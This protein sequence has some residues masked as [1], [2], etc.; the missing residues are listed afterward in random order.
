[1]IG[2]VIRANADRK[3][4]L[5]MTE[6]ER[7]LLV[8]RREAKEPSPY[9]EPDPEDDGPSYEE[10]YEMDDFDLLGNKHYPGRPDCPWCARLAETETPQ[11]I[12]SA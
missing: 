6:E 8:A 2:D 12:D 7:A 3:P 1:M 4:N 5:V 11:T 9:R 10:V